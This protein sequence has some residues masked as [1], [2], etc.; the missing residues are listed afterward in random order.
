MKTLMQQCVFA[1]A[2]L[3]ALSGLAA[4]DGADSAIIPLGDLEIYDLFDLCPPDERMRMNVRVQRRGVP[5]NQ[6]AERRITNALESG[7]RSAQLYDEQASPILYI[8]VH[9]LRGTENWG[10]E[11]AF[12]IEISY[13]RLLQLPSSPPSATLQHYA[14]TRNKNLL[15][16]GDMDLIMEALNQIFDGFLV[17]YLRIRDSKACKLLRSR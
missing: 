15:G 3:V 7:L 11:Q 10:D 6:N 2:L 5:F 8:V 4:E 14:V 9:M 16:Y 12:S 17:E 1:C 13:Y